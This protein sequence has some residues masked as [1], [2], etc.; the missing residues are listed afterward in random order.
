MATTKVT[1]QHKT[2]AIYGAGYT[3]WGQ[4]LCLVS[5]IKTL[6][7]L[8]IRKIQ[9]IICLIPTNNPPRNFAVNVA[10]RGFFCH[11]LMNELSRAVL[12]IDGSNWY[13]G[14]KG[15]R[16]N[17]IDLDHRK[18]AE[19]LLK[20][21]RLAE[22]RYYVGQVSGNRARIRGQEKLLKVLRQQGMNIFLGRIEKREI[23]PKDNPIT[24]RLKSIIDEHGEHIEQDI[25]TQL[26][27]LCQQAI[28]TFIEKQV[29]VQIAVDLVSM[30]H[31][32]KYDVAYLL[33]ADGDFVPAVEEVKRMDKRI[34]AA[35]ALTKRQ[36][37][38]SAVDSFIP[39][40]HKWFCDCY[41]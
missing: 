17:L 37:L 39:L 41:L 35:S 23:S 20:D 31:R 4:I 11:P 36:Q 21:R 5:R 3:G 30:A 34:F 27:H 19:K 29:D 9:A 32:N 14:L 8:D 1:S 25:R 26:E 10:P 18:V 13:H 33:S 40:K 12:F 7:T 28:P 22:I 15:I 16:V 6:K 2:T 38:G 24:S